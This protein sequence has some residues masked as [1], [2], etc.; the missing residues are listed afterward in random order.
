MFQDLRG[1]VVQIC[2]F[3]GKNVSDDVIDRV[4]EKTS[5]KNM[6]TDTRIFIPNTIKDAEKGTFFRKGM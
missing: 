3:L 5:F 4:V 1:A 2:G 6:K